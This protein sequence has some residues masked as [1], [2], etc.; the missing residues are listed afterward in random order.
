MRFDQYAGHCIVSNF[1]LHR[2]SHSQ[3]LTAT[4]TPSAPTSARFNLI[5]LSS[6][7]WPSWLLLPAASA[8]NGRV[9]SLR[10]IQIP[11]ISWNCIGE[12]YAIGSFTF[13]LH[14][15]P[16]P[17]LAT[18]KTLGFSTK[19]HLHCLH[20]TRFCGLCHHPPLSNSGNVSGHHL[21][22]SNK[23]GCWSSFVSFVASC[24]SVQFCHPCHLSTYSRCLCLLIWTWNSTML[25][26][27]SPAYSGLIHHR[28]FFTDS[29]KRPP[30]LFAAFKNTNLLFQRYLD[31]G[32]LI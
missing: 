31:L 22:G 7:D 10:I 11:C 32:I 2:D 18:F 1:E 24:S 4:E 17:T 27:P 19:L 21:A 3:I 28:A 16:T 30:M 23:T 25:S 6:L 14:L 8:F 26:S 5:R 12:N 9:P 29:T 15:L 20:L 13:G